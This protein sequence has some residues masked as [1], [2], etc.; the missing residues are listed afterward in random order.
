M[1]SPAATTAAPS[2][3]PSHWLARGDGSAGAPCPTVFVR[4]VWRHASTPSRPQERSKSPCFAPVTKERLS[5]KNLDSSLLHKLSRMPTQTQQHSRMLLVCPLGIPVWVMLFA[6]SR[7]AY[8]VINHE[9]PKSTAAA[10]RQRS[11][12][13]TCNMPPYTIHANPCKYKRT[14]PTT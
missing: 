6:P 14:T 12:M 1:R 3:R 13:A 8:R 9:S 11:G 2:L 5:C 7:N 4:L 10:P